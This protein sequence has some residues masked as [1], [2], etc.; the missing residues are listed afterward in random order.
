MTKYCTF[1]V[2]IL[3]NGVI[4]ASISSLASD[5]A[6]TKHIL[7]LQDR[8]AGVVLDIATH[9][10]HPS[11]QYILPGRD[12][13]PSATSRTIVTGLV[14]ASS[15]ADARTEAIDYV[16][17]NGH[18]LTTNA[19]ILLQHAGRA[20]FPAPVPCQH[21][22]QHFHQPQCAADALDNLPVRSRLDFDPQPVS[23]IILDSGSY[24]SRQFPSIHIFR[25]VP[26]MAVSQL[27]HCLLYGCCHESGSQ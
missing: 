5:T 1:S 19:A 10:Q 6:P 2:I 26:L 18:T 8:Q 3:S 11:S 4:F 21:R 9:R 7:T 20:R 12:Q 24:S 15:S 13:A 25:P 22:R 27:R 16:Q 23:T 17:A 14:L